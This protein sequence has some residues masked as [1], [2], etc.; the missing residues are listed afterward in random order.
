LSEPNRAIISAY[1]IRGNGVGTSTPF[2]SLTIRA[3]TGSITAMMSSSSTKDIS[4]SSCVNSN[5]RS[6]RGFSSRKHRTIW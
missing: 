2:V 4:T 1:A 3:I 5:P 6:A